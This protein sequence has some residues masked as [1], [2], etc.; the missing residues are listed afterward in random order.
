VV[1]RNRS[2]LKETPIVTKVE[3][4]FET[5]MMAHRY[6]YYVLSC[7]VLDDH[8]YTELEHKAQQVCSQKSPVHKIGSSNED[9]YTKKQILAAHILLLTYRGIDNLLFLKEYYV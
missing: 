8:R 7:P 9:D 2:I 1:S 5:T 6:L 3:R 4:I